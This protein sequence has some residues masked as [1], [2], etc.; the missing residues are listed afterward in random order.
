V[1]S[2]RD[3]EI[4]DRRTIEIVYT[5]VVA[6]LTVA[7]VYGIAVIVGRRLGWSDAE[8]WQRSC[9]VGLAL[10]SFTGAVWASRSLYRFEQRARRM[11]SSG[12]ADCP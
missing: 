5:L 7:A 9:D 4:H 10:L 3:P 6:V 11:T 8:G 12:W 1:P 2:S